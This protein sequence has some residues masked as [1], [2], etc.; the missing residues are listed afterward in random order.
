MTGENSQTINWLTAFGV[1]RVMKRLRA[2]AGLSQEQLAHRLGVEREWV[3]G[4]ERGRYVLRMHSFIGWCKACNAHPEKV[5]SEL[6]EQS[7]TSTEPST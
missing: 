3:N 1:A 4:I 5:V 6:I 7:D 2:S